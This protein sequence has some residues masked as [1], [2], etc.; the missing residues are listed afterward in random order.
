VDEK[1]QVIVHEEAF[2]KGPEND[3]LEPMIDAVN[4]NFKAIGI[5]G[6]ICKR[7]KLP[8]MPVFTARLRSK[9]WPK[10]A[11]MPMWQTINFGNVIRNS[12]TR[13]NT[14]NVPEMK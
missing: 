4:K 6:D 5:K 12:Q 9:Y 8:Q 7:P 3:L 13:T 14:R 10:K 1:N 11:S 2:G